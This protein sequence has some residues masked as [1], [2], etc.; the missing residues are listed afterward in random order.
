MCALT[1][2]L[3]VFRL[4]S[5]GSDVVESYLSRARAAGVSP[6]AGTAVRYPRSTSAPRR[7]PASTSARA[8]CAQRWTRRAEL[9]DVRIVEAM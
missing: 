1:S 3:P 6:G 5:G 7:S 4:K 9:A 2:P 8:R